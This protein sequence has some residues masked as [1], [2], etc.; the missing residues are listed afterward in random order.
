MPL[1]G[2]AKVAYMKEWKAKN[3]EK[4]H[5]Y[6]AT[7]MPA[8]YAQNREAAAVKGA[9]YYQANKEAVRKRT[10]KWERENP[11]KRK[12][13]TALYRSRHLDRRRAACKA[14]YHRNK[15]KAIES[16]IRWKKKNPEK[17]TAINAA[18]R[19]RNPEREKAKSRRSH[20]LRRTRKRSAVI[21]NL[22]II[23]RWEKSVRSKRLAVCF[24]CKES[25]P[26]KKVQADH[27]VALARGG[28]HDISNLCSSC[29]KCN[30][31][32]NSKTVEKWNSELIHPV[33]L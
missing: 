9:A 32:K 10:A 17:V 16:A 2:E 31:R 14:W 24:W 33:L 1:T 26:S 7:Y 20:H 15:A 23:A 6:N 5:A 12:V 28:S 3:R 25:F 29:P 8:Y 11:E 22:K 13:H 21:G 4:I 27:I 18:C 19:K 30:Q